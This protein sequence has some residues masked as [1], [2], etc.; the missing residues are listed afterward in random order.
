MKLIVPIDCS[1]LVRQISIFITLLL[2]RHLLTQSPETGDAREVEPE[3]SSFW[4]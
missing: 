2:R 3:I 1:S 4:I